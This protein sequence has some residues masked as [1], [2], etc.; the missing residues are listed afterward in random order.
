[1]AAWTGLRLTEALSGLNPGLPEQAIEEA[2]RKI[3]RPDS[4]SLETI[5]RSFHQMLAHGIEV[6]T[7]GTDGSIRG[8]R[9]R[10]ADYENPLNNDWLAVNQVTMVDGQHTR[11]PDVVLFLN[12]LP[13]AVI[14]LKSATSEGVTIDS[15]W[16]PS[17]ARQTLNHSLPAVS[18]PTLALM[19]SEITSSSL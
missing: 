6:E 4:P 16:N 13:I 19:P 3:T 18:E 10:L 14:E 9:L 15:A 7:R 17:I 1:M 12:G 8:E 11:R 2:I 5:N